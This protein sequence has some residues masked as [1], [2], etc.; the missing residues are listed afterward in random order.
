MMKTVTLSTLAALTMGF[1]GTASYADQHTAAG[2]AAWRGCRACH[3]ITGPDG[4]VIQR[5]GRSGPN[6]Y[7]LAGRAVASAEGFG[8]SDPIQTYAAGGA[9]WT[10]ENF[11]AYVTNPTSFLRAELDDNSVRSAMSFQMRSGAEDMW[12]YLE[13]I[14][15][16]EDSDDGDAE[17]DGDG[18]AEDDDS[19]ETE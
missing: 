2:E 17:D 14:A 4:D 7:G 18:D 9:V 8:Y 5:G 1:T 13:S 16:A 3:S 6:L 15:P 11:V 19:T 12:A 10:E